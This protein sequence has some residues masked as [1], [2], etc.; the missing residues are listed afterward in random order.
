MPTFIVQNFP[1]HVLTSPEQSYGIV[2]EITATFT[3]S[4]MPAAMAANN[5]SYYINPASIVLPNDIGTHPVA[6]KIA[7]LNYPAIQTTYNF[8]IIVS[9]TVTNLSVETAVIN[10]DYVINSGTSTKGTFVPVQSP[11]CN[12]P[13]TFSV[14]QINA[15]I[16]VAGDPGNFNSGTLNYGFSFTNTA[17]IGTIQEFILTASVTNPVGL[18]TITGTNNLKIRIVPDCNLPNA[19]VSRSVASYTYILGKNNIEGSS[20][21]TEDIWFTDTTA[22]FFANSIYCGARSYSFSPSSPSW[23]SITGSAPTQVLT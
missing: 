1:F 17:L 23:L 2:C 13:V 18:T 7:L 14:Q 15:G 20:G 5:L 11:N 19:L 12:L 9:C 10:F 22:S 21:L 4:Y 3:T 16:P 8:N 6:V